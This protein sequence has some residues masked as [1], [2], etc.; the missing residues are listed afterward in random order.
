MRP[1][2]RRLD[3]L[4][5]RAAGTTLWVWGIRHRGLWPKCTI[6]VRVGLAARRE[7]VGVLHVLH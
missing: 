7:A 4:F 2:V 1:D 3:T 5:R 6:Q